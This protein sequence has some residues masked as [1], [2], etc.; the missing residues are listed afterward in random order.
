MYNPTIISTGAVPADGTE[1]NS[2]ARKSERINSTAVVKDVRPVLPPA[3]T[4]AELSTKVVT[5]EVPNNAPTVVPIASANKACLQ[6]GIVVLPFL[7]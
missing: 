2:G 4:P 7:S 6:L 5:V 1:E 3:T